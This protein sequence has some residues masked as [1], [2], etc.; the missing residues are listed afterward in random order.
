MSRVD[1]YHLQKWP[2][3]RALPELLERV[4]ANGLRAVVATG[5]AER[6]QALDDV[7]W[8]YKEDSW[9]PHGSVSTV[10]VAAKQAANNPIWLTDTVE[11]PNNAG[12]LVITEGVDTF[13]LNTFDRCLDLFDGNIVEHV[14]AAR[15]RWKEAKEAGHALHYWQQDDSGRW[16]EK[17]SANVPEAN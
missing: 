9:L 6:V 15:G 1:F 14:E 16:T 4:V 10:G 7:L 13:D 8:S 11:N 2:L 17:A 12:V 3:E 5:S